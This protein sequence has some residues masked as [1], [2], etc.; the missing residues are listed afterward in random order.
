MIAGMHV[1]IISKLIIKPVTVVAAGIFDHR[2][3][4]FDGKTVTDTYLMLYHCVSY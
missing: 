2:Y 3:P 1:M 4:T